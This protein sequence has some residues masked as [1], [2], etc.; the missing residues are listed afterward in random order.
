GR[1]VARDVLVEALWPDEDPSVTSNRLSVALSTVR[2][3]LDP[4]RRL[5]A[6]HLIDADRTS[7]RLS[8]EHAVVDVEVFLQEAYEGLDLLA[9]GRAAEALDRLV[10]AEALYAGDFLEDDQYE[11]WSVALREQARATYISATA[12]L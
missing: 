9:R 10:D 8:L 12:A 1:P 7:V 3:L 2:K 11:D 5:P 6:E 4:D